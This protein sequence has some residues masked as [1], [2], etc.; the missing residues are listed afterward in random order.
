[1]RIL[2]V[3]AVLLS[4]AACSRAIVGAP[5]AGEVPATETTATTTEARVTDC[6]RDEVEAAIDN[7]VVAQT[8]TVGTPPA[9]EDIL[10]LTTIVDAPAHGSSISTPNGCVADYETADFSRFGR[11][12][13]GFSSPV[14]HEPVA[15][16]EFAGSTLIESVLSDEICEYGLAINDAVR[17]FDHGSWVTVRVVSAEGNPPAC[18]LAR[19]LIE[20]AAG[21]LPDTD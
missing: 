11:V 20:T 1:M 9:C 15:I 2:I 16:S 6:D 10:P 17:H 4:T 12:L 19:Q 8:K 21:N 5:V 14:S 18:G 7:P 13:M 3:V